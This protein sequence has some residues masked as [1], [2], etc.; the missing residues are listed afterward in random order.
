MAVTFNDIVSRVKQQLLGFTR[1]QESISY[2]V[3]PM[4]ATDITFQADPETVSSLS[5][6]LVE[7]DDEL[8]LVKKFDK[9]SGVVSLMADIA[10]RGAENTV[11][12]D[13]GINTFV[14]NDPKYPK[15]RIKEAINDAIRGTYPDLWVFGEF[16]FPYTAARYEYPMPVQAEDVYKVVI[17]TIG[18]SKVWFPATR[19]RFNPLASTGDQAVSGAT[20][21]SIQVY[22]FVV[23]GRNVRVSYRH[24][25]TELTLD[26]DDFEL[27]T[28]FPERYVDM[29]VYSA[30]WRL[31]PAMESARLQQRSIEATERSALVPTGAA[32]D[33]SQYYLGLYQRRLLEEQSRLQELYET[34]ATFNG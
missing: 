14:I 29:I 9:G 15:A 32:N 7:M 34:Y 17:N 19:W 23:P 12:A 21:R 4:L 30:C 25:P 22:D 16:E 28:G 18:P 11:P 8:L 1:D 2:L 26:E 13:H 31:L 27:T 10:G 6:G 20:G 3:A 24:R 5:R 33:A